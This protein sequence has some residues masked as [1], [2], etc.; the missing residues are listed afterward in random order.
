MLDFLNIKY[1]KMIYFF[2]IC[3][4]YINAFILDDMQVTF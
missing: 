3:A 1:H 4:L 2:I